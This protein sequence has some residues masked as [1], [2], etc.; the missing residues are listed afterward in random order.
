LAHHIPSNCGVLEA[1]SVLVTPVAL[2]ISTYDRASFV[3]VSKH[4]NRR[5]QPMQHC[6]YCELSAIAIVDRVNMVVF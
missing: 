6:D 4:L 2:H 5:C 3:L 1:W